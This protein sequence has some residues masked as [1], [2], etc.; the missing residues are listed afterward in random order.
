MLSEYE[1]Y[2]L[3]SANTTVTIDEHIVP[4]ATFGEFC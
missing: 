3:F 1:D 2:N 4:A